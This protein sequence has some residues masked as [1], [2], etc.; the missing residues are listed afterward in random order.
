MAARS[1]IAV[2]AT[3]PATVIEDYRRVMHLADY[4]GTL[5]PDRDLVIKLNL[6]WT[7]FFPACSTPPWALDG[8]LRTLLADGFRR[9]RL[10]PAENK[11]VVT[12]PWRGAREN[13][14]L[15]VLDRHGLAFTALPEVEWTTYRFRSPLLALD[16]LF[17]RGIEVPKLLIGRDMLHL[18]TMKTHGHST[19]TGAVKN[20]FGGLLKE[21][22]HYGHK[23]I[24]EVLVD[25]LTMQ[26]ELHPAVFAVMDA[27]VAGNGAGP[28]TMEPRSVN[29]LLAGADS[30]ALD[31]IAAR[32]MGFDPLSIPYLRM[33]HE[34][35]LGCADPAEIELVGDDVSS[36]DLGFHVRRSFVIY[37]DQFIRKGPLR[38]LEGLLL[39]SPLAFWAPLASTIYHDWYWYPLRGRRIVGQFLQTD[40]GR[41]F[42]RYR[43]HDPWASDPER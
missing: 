19:T 13:V 38:R 27:T 31:A 17:P 14:W 6:S 32:I 25:L 5:S 39:H 3:S 20:A 10:I 1:R 2:V 29:H 18:P 12:D 8:V 11:T 28:R 26:R 9:D 41:L 7:R 30:V 34:R 15:P 36:L 24:H 23:Y 35:G 22:R 37:G 42:E 40:W 4:Q 16:G 43:G 21:F 33:A